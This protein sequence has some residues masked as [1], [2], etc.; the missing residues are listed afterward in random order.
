MALEDYGASEDFFEYTDEYT[1]CF[2]S[3]E[4]IKSINNMLEL[5]NI[6]DEAMRNYHHLWYTYLHHQNCTIFCINGC[7]D[8]NKEPLRYLLA[9]ENWHYSIVDKIRNDSDKGIFLMVASIYPPCTNQEIVKKFRIE[10]ICKF[11]KKISDNRDPFLNLMK[12]TKQSPVYSEDVI[13]VENSYN[14]T[15]FGYTIKN[16]SRVSH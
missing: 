12:H 5:I 1:L 14:E 4:N 13:K 15:Q 9:E 11:I 8:C 7:A 16:S 3:D 10:S 6:T 2:D